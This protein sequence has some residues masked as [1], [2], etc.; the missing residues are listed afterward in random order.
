MS[1]II[2]KKLKCHC[3]NEIIIFYIKDLYEK[4]YCKKCKKWMECTQIYI[5][6]VELELSVSAIDEM[7]L[8]GDG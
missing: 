5:E 8:K 6:S 2:N 1:E 7:D 3:G 4:H